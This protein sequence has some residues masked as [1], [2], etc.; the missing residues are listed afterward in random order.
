LTSQQHKKCVL[1]KGDTLAVKDR[2]RDLGGKWNGPLKGW[3][4]Q[5][6]RGV[7]ATSALR[8]EG[9]T[10]DEVAGTSGEPPQKV[11]RKEAARKRKHADDDDDDDD[12]DDY[13]DDDDFIVHDK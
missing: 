13:D 11:D 5:A 3:I 12:D 10:V 4:F 8:S 1:I 9:I 6:A 7:E 2:L